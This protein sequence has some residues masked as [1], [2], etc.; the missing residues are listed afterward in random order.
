MYQN[1][2][3]VVNQDISHKIVPGGTM[4]PTSLNNGH[5]P[6]AI[7][8]TGEIIR[9]MAQ[10]GTFLV[11]S[12]AVPDEIGTHH[13][14]PLKGFLHPVKDIR[15]IPI[16]VPVLDSTI[17]HKIETTEEVHSGVMIETGGQ[18]QEQITSATAVHHHHY[19]GLHKV[20]KVVLTPPCDLAPCVRSP[21]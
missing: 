12:K 3:T 5:Y 13:Q 1:A 4:M 16:A 20:L 2:I 9:V 8:P 11:I 17:H 6:G 15:G 10:N 21:T 18:V 19:L 7:N 14:V